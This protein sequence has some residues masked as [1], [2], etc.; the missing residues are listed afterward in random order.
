MSQENIEL[1][2][3]GQEGFNRGDMGPVKHLLSA[4]LDWGAMSAFPGL[5]AAYSGHEGIDAW[6]KTVRSSF[7]S[8]EVSLERVVHDGGD[9]VAVTEHLQAIG[10]ESRA[11]VEM[12]IVSVY[13]FADGRIAKRRAFTTEEEALAAAKA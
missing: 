5:D 10:R 8:F 6:M 12:T 7:S 2:R 3:R 9:V 13:W 11:E 4:D 1:I